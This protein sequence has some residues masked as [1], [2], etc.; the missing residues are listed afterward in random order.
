MAITRGACL[1]SNTTAL[2]LPN[3]PAWVEASIAFEPGALLPFVSGGDR[4]GW[5]RDDLR[6]VLGARWS[7]H[8]VVRDGAMHFADRFD[9]FDARRDAMSEVLEHLRATGW[10]RGWRNEHYSV[11]GESDDAPKFS[12]ERA[13]VRRFGV[14]G[15]AAHVNGYTRTPDGLAL[16]I[17]ERSASKQID[18]GRLDNLVGGGIAVGSTPQATLIK[19]CWEEAGIP[20]AMAQRAVA[21]GTL[22]FACRDEE[23]VDANLV[24]AFDLEL[25]P[26]FTPHNQDGEVARFERVLATELPAR[27]AET[28]RFTLD[29]ALVT[30]DWLAR[31]RG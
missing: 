5:V 6:M 12:M 19:E 9:S 1:I 27:L 18:A 25:P 3:L 4:V 28:N 29:A 22:R 20:A 17:G 11:Y 7:S 31:H 14:R 26:N 30:A 10:V 2:Q 8:F 24:H 16:W 15:Q 13:A 23:G 21:I